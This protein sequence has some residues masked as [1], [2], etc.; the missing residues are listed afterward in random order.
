MPENYKKKSSA[1]KPDF[2]KEA[3]SDFDKGLQM[4]LDS[5]Q[6]LIMMAGMGFAELIKLCYRHYAITIGALAALFVFTRHLT[7]NAYHVDFLVSIFPDFF[8]QSRI[9]WFYQFTLNQHHYTVFSLCLFFISV[10]LGFSLRFTRTKFSRIF[11]I[12]GLSNGEGD[13]PK[14]VYK[15]RLDKY[16]TEYDFDAN[17]IGISEFENKKERIEARFKMEIE[18]IKHGKHRGRI[19][20]TFNKRTF[21]E[22]I[23]YGEISEEKILNLDSF[24]VGYSMEGILTQK[25]SDLPHMII[26][27]TTGSGKSIFFKSCLLSLLESSP[28]VPSLQLYIIDLKGG[29]EAIDFK[30]APN[31]RI[32]K[33][34][35]ESVLLLR[36]VDKEMKSRFRYL[37]EKGLKN[38]VPG[39]DKKERIV[40]A[41]DEASVLYMI[42]SKYDDDYLDAMEA[43]RLADS[44]AKLSRAASI[45]LILATQK[46]DKQVIPTSVSENICRV[47]LGRIAF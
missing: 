43:R 10:V 19:L 34:M 24:Y 11:L 35:R 25:I 30:A 36:K 2:A 8:T 21:P 6:E 29:L 16:R 5:L 38:I 14:L 45:H 20:I 23:T 12:A 44:I 27:G 22:S 17:G 37:E 7:K 33:T 15:R 3:M 32:I 40:V 46:L 4:A 28:C 26:S 42:R 31:V 13:T 18:S 39:R 41:V 1:T 9:E 47:D